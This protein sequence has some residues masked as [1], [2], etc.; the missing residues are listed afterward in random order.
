MD[1]D[2]RGASRMT[3]KN[4]RILEF[5]IMIQLMKQLMN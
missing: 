2:L 3:G 5:S 4:L 1:L